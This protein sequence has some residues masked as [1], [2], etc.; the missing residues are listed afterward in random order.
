M[1]SLSLSQKNELISLL[2]TRFEQ[3][4]HRHP[5]LEWAQVLPKLD[6]DRLLQTLS[7]MEQTGGEPDV[8]Q[9]PSFGTS[10]VFVDC[11]KETPAGR[12]SLCYDRPALDARKANKPANSALDLAASM[13]IQLL[14]EQEYFE[15]QSLD[16]VDTK[17]SSWLLTPA[18]VRSRGGA[19]FGDH[20]FGRTF[21]YHNG[22]DSYYAVRG[23]RGKVVVK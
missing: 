8:V 5:A 1:P 18:D 16:T 11:A 21:I 15:L 3:H 14:D 2:K 13:G 20:R 12:R 7:A 9:L 10:L 6:D 17:T 22:A 4:P 23:F 19:L